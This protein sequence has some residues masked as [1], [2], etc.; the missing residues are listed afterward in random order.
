MLRWLFNISAAVSLVLC[1]ASVVM[2]VRSMSTMDRLWHAT[3]GDDLIII[4][5]GRGH[6]SLI[7]ADGLGTAWLKGSSW[8]Y[9]TFEATSESFDHAVKSMWWDS[10]GH[11]EFLGFRVLYNDGSSPRNWGP[12]STFWC[13]I[14]PIWMI[15]TI[16]AVPP[17]YWLLTAPRVRR[18]RMRKGLCPTCGYDL[19]GSTGACPECGAGRIQS[20]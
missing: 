3:D 8:N 9:R 12:G 14:A 10:T 17:A 7:K 6:F 13:V 18:R 4:S 15:V 2:W 20:Q 5:S 19:R 1:V 16:T 11:V